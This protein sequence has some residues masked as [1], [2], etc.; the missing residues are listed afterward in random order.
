MIVGVDG[1]N[2]R[3][4]G[5]LTH[6][7]H[8]LAA[9]EPGAHGIDRIV[10]WGGRSTLARLP[11]RPWLERV[12]ERLLDRSLPW[13]LLWQRF[14]L[15][16]LVGRCD[17]LFAPGGSAP[18][19]AVP[20]VTMSRNMLPFEPL[21]LRRYG[22]SPTALRLRLLRF[23]Q[24][25]TFRRADALIFLTRYARDAVL[26]AVPTQARTAII[27]HGV[28]DALRRK[29][30]PPRALAECSAERPFRLLYVSIVDQYK[31]PWHVAQAVARLR[32]D[33][34]PV[35][36]RFVGPEYPAA[37]RRFRKTL[38]ALDPERRFLQY[39]GPAAPEELPK[40]YAS[41]DAFVFAS[42]CEN[43]P[44]ILLEAMASGLPIACAE[45]GPMPEVLGDA[46]VYFD[47]E[48]PEDIAR[49][50][51]RLLEDPALRGR[52]AELAY[53]QAMAY[54]WRRCAA[55]TLRFIAET[56]RSAGSTGDR[57]R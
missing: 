7:R 54:T 9:A 43:M 52:C 51:R 8:V 40:I 23:G 39:E 14:A 16:R 27:P 11:E 37:G 28:D 2:I 38:D 22:V 33:G 6:L 24:G 13:R 55:E 32:A 34:L 15:P 10:V 57:R 35:C 29:P 25:R 5:G 17:V 46:G 36:A 4:G 44:N 47:P 45:R 50:L 53:S 31:H 41:A 48:R 56:P 30:E 18:H 3:T 20:V 19:A 42:S 1:S 26:R 12:H 49:S 21:E